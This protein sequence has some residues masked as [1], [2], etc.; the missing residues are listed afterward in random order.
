M[1]QCTTYRD[2]SDNPTELTQD[3]INWFQKI[4]NICKAAVGVCIPIVTYDFELLSGKAKDAVGMF[5]TTDVK[6]PLNED[7]YIAIDCYTIHELYD[8]EF[9]NGSSLVFDTLEVIIAHELA[10][11][12][13][14][15]HCK[16]HRT[17][18][19]EFLE[20]IHEYENGMKGE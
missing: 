4:A 1:L 15:R 9:N 10:H 14:F 20:R 11:G 7:A 2:C 8:V 17:I 19:A 16:R 13:Q 6:N 5:R 12:F 3:E 18:T